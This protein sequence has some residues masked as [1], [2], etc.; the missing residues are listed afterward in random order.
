MAD[1]IT[2]GNTYTEYQYITTTTVTRRVV[3]YR[4]D[5]AMCI[6]LGPGVTLR[7]I[8]VGEDEAWSGSLGP[9]RHEVANTGNVPALGSGFIYHSGEFDQTPD[10]YLAQFIPAENLPG[11][12]GF[13][14]IIFKGVDASVLSGAGYSFDVERLTDYLSL[15]ADRTIGDDLNPAEGM[16]DVILNDWGTIGVPAEFVDFD[17]FAS[18]GAQYAGDGLGA[19]FV[20]YSE[21]FGVNL[22]SN[23]QTQTRSVLYVDPDTGTIRVKPLRA[24]AFDEEAAVS[25]TN[26]NIANLQR[27]EKSG[28]SEFPTHFKVSFEN[29]AKKYEDDYIISINPAITPTNDRSRRVSENTL[30]T[31]KTQSSAAAVLG[32]FMTYESSPRLEFTIQAN[33]DAAEILPGEPFLVSWPE[34]GLVDYPL[35]ATKIAEQGSTSNYVMLTCQQYD[36]TQVNDFFAVPEPSQHVPLNLGPQTPEA[37]FIISAPY[38]YLGRFGFEQSLEAVD[39]GNFPLMF[40]RPAS[41]FQLFSDVRLTSDGSLIQP[42]IPYA[43]HAKFAKPI[44]LYANV[45]DYIT[46]RVTIKDVVNPDFLINQ[47]LAGVYEGTRLIYTPFEIMSYETFEDNGDGTYDLINVHRALL[48]TVL[49]PHDVDDDIVIADLRAARMPQFYDDIGD[50]IEFSFYSRSHK[51]LG[52]TPLV[53]EWEGGAFARS[54]A[55][56]PPTGVKINSLDTTAIVEPGEVVTFKAMHRRRERDIRLF[57]DA[58]FMEDWNPDITSDLHTFGIVLID[59]AGTSHFLGSG[60]YGDPTT[61]A[62]VGFDTLDTTIPPTAAIGSGIVLF[63][64]FRMEAGRT[65]EDQLAG[66]VQQSYLAEERPI[67]IKGPLDIVVD[68]SFDYEVNP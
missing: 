65:A 11:Y 19:G 41:E 59:S 12:V 48:D 5:A 31:V 30:S 68:L 24:N 23:F 38:Y 50:P 49:A 66:L 4:V 40:P 52:T 39:N 57:G 43:L 1:Y 26:S 58:H 44:K 45:F 32:L 18:A 28:W 60:A 3:G 6:C 25:L 20:A 62:G 42:D 51:G 13:A 34:Y 46:P 36:N 56:L 16:A 53:M 14:Y 27:M 10:P 54:S 55:I 2:F 61:G 15:G 29:R 33:R 37:G 17:S 47:E 21:N 8:W 63:S 22:L 64:G 67:Y 7:K 35:F 9:G